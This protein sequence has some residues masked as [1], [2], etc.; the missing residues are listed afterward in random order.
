M[1]YL[2]SISPFLLQEH[3]EGFVKAI[4]TAIQRKIPTICQSPLKEDQLN[5]ANIPKEALAALLLCLN[6]IAPALTSNELKEPILAMM[7]NSRPLLAQMSARPTGTIRPQSTPNVPPV[8]PV[9]PTPRPPPPTSMFAPGPAGQA[10][11]Q[12]QHGGPDPLAGLPGQLRD[13]LNLGTA[14]VSSASSAFSALP[15]NSAGN[16]RNMSP[17]S[18]NRLFG[19]PGAPV[20]HTPDGGSSPSLLNLGIG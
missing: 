3:G 9:R 17:G 19:P 14:P 16:F 5:K 8:G 12:Q 1:V 20:A 18:P 11:V 10:A 6:Q 13:S 4:A 2:V 15:G 7:E